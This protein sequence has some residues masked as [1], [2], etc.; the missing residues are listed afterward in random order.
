MSLYVGKRKYLRRPIRIPEE[1]HQL[2]IYALGLSRVGKSWLLA[3]LALQFNAQ[4]EGVVVIDHKDGQLAREIVSR[5]DPVKLR[6]IAPGTCYFDKQAHHWGLNILEVKHRDRLGF[7]QVADHAVSIFELMERAEFRTMAQMELWL[8]QATLL[9]LYLPQ[10]TILDV[11]RI[12]TEQLFRKLIL[13]DPRVP[14]EL[15]ETWNRFDDNKQNTA[16]SR[17]SSVNSSIPRLK[18]ILSVPAIYYMVTQPKST[19]HLQEWLD[20]GCMVV[21]DTAT[22]MSQG[23]AKLL[24]DLILALLINETF[25]RREPDRVWRVVA[26]EFDQL[27]ASNMYRLIDKAGAYKVFPIM[28]HQTL[29]QLYRDNDPRLYDSIT[30]SPIKFTFRVGPSDADSKRVKWAP[31]DEL[32]TLPRY[33]AYLTHSDGVSGLLDAGTAELILLDPL[34]GEDDEAALAA[35]ILSQKAHTISERELVRR[36]KIEGYGAETTRSNRPRPLEETGQPK[37]P[38][39]HPT[40]LPGA[41][42]PVDLPSPIRVASMQAALPEPDQP[43][44]GHPHRRVGQASRQPGMPPPPQKPRPGRRQGDRPTGQPVSQVGA[45]LPDQGRSPGPDGVPSQP[46]PGHPTLPPPDGADLPDD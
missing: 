6:Y 14:D 38:G 12:L 1:R 27:A 31:L 11:R 43:R 22:G 30:A 13:I 33:Q 18:S 23:S 8:T 39:D 9:A 42:L 45:E 19:I 3:N 36:G 34:Q 2:P 7:A 44:R 32:T 40:G 35:A 37:A 28:A 46:R 5:C 17:S 25:S 20:E 41:E 29:A 15:R 10:P 16:Y 21:V 4:G 24:A 26:D